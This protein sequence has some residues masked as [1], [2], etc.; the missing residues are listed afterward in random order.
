VIAKSRPEIE[1]ANRKNIQM[2]LAFTY[3]DVS[4]ADLEA[5]LKVYEDKDSRWVRDIIQ[6]AIEEQ[7]RPSMEQGARAVKKV[8]Q[9]HK[10]KQT[11]FAPKCG[12]SESPN[13]DEPEQDEPVDEARTQE[14]A[15]AKP[16]VGKTAAPESK[17]VASESK[18]PVADGKPA[19]PANNVAVPQ[20][21]PAAE[22]KVAAL[23]QKTAVPHKR[24]VHRRA[25]PETDLR[26]CLSLA[27]NA[28]IIACAEK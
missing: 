9:A 4:D 3:R 6:G 26:A 2:L 22:R 5:Y 24:R 23:D 7:F 8:V 14:Q 16:Q 12:Q 17:P 15:V 19:V 21:K 18:I 10:R 1:K 20:K 13:Q 27:T 11:M 25:G 28:E